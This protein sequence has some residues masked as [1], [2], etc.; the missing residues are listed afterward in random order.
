MTA[1][2][3]QPN[4]VAWLIALVLLAALAVA[5]GL[6][7]GGEVLP[8]KSLVPV[9]GETVDGEKVDDEKAPPAPADGVRYELR[10][11][12]PLEASE[13]ERGANGSRSLHVDVQGS[14]R[15]HGLPIPVELLFGK[16]DGLRHVNLLVDRKGHAVWPSGSEAPRPRFADF[17]FPT[18]GG[19]GKTLT[20]GT[21]KVGLVMPPTCVLDIE[22]VEVDGEVTGEAMT[23]YV[24]SAAASWPA[25]R[26]RP[27]KM[28]GGR[29]KVLCEAAG[30]RIEVRGLVTSGRSMRASFMASEQEG[31]RVPCSIALVPSNG[32][33]V[34]LQGMPAVVETTTNP[35]RVELHDLVHAPVLAHRW[36]DA[37]QRYVSFPLPQV[38]DATSSWLVLASHRAQKAQLWWGVR[39]AG[40]SVAMQPC[41]SVA[42]GRVVDQ[43]GN[44]APGCHVDLVTREQRVVLQSVTTGRDG[45]FALTGPDPARVA[46]DVA[47]REVR[48]GT[49][50]PVSLPAAGNLEFEV[51]R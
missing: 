6:S 48:G 23:A 39:E 38:R 29:A 33:E 11:E 27:V 36:P 8:D 20:A 12:V 42:V 14:E 21:D 47:V 34:A 51:Q 19:T 17:A 37:A 2:G 15:R 1:S 5:A 28:V 46:L 49:P 18:I 32:F 45:A 35:W 9:D 41:V 13:I 50:L 24:R 31:E 40:E 4:R 7:G 26:W 16:R 22:V 25:N 10:N 43:D 3:P 44:A 30:Q